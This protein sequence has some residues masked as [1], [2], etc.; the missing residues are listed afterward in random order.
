MSPRLKRIAEWSV[1]GLFIVI[2]SSFVSIQIYRSAVDSDWY[3]EK[4]ARRS[5]EQTVEK[6]N[7]I[8]SI[9]YIEVDDTVEQR[10]IYDAPDE[11]FDDIEIIS[12]ERTRDIEKLLE[13][14]RSR[15]C[16]TVF[17]NDKTAAS[18]Y[19]TEDGKVCW[20]ELFELEC[21]SLLAWYSEVINEKQ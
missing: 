20:G 10:Y 12:Y 17:F 13:I 19:I 4:Q 7:D 9:K 21:P 15:R 5:L 2:F 8:G 3:T 16:V 18:F 1:I 6:V 11:L 14:W